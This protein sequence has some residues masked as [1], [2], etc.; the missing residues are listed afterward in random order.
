[1]GDS[2]VAKGYFL[3]IFCLWT[4]I[5]LSQV[6]LPRPLQA[7]NCFFFVFFGGF[8]FLMEYLN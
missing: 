8:R 4:T 5:L 3:N 1:V 2:Q 6:N 7:S